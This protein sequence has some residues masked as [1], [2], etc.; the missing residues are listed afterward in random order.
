MTNP[1][2]IHKYKIMKKM[3]FAIIA[4]YGLV[5][6]ANAQVV[7]QK[8][9]FHSTPPNNDF[10]ASIVRSHGTNNSIV[11]GVDYSTSSLGVHKLFLCSN[12]SFYITPPV[13][14]GATFSNYSISLPDSTITV[15]DMRVLGNYT[16]L[17][18]KIKYNNS[19]VGFIGWV[20][21][22]DFFSSSPG[23]YYVPIP[24]VS[25]V[26]KMVVYD[27]YSPN[28][29]AVAIGE[30]YYNDAYGLH[31]DFFVIELDNASLPSASYQYINL[32]GDDILHEVHYSPKHGVFIVEYSISTNALA[33]RK[34]EPSAVV[35]DP[36]IWTMYYYSTGD[37][38]VYSATHSAIS[39]NKLAVSYL[40]SYGSTY[41]TRI[42]YF[43]LSNMKMLNSQEFQL[44][45][46]SEPYDMV[47]CL[48]GSEW[49]PIL[50]QPFSIGTSFHSNFITLHPTLTSPHNTHTH[51]YPQEIYCSADRFPASTHYIAVGHKTMQY[52]QDAS[53][54]YILPKKCIKNKTLRINIISS[55]TRNDSFISLIYQPGL[56]SLHTA[57]A[58]NG[59]NQSVIFCYDE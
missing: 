50:V 47:S 56:E 6:A 10:V 46:K 11:Y 23:F 18:G 19:F 54:N 33:I 43:D 52:M 36:T 12:L 17:C 29:K 51:F 41:T 4:L 34:A 58:N 30:N 55:V 20:N 13:P 32:L 42:R 59:S 8:T 26:K 39:H 3:L 45:D 28:P 40:Y 21:N 14:V 22:S 1:T 38:E 35:A 16:Y 44:P 25:F 9:D 31:R 49:T 24:E 15:Y 57:N 48:S 2:S 53:F 37:D 5:E 7:S 27:D